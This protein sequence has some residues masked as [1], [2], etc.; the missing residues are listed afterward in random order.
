MFWRGRARLPIENPDLSGSDALIVPRG[1]EEEEEE[2]K[3]SFVPS[4][5]WSDKKSY[6]FLGRSPESVNKK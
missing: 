6:R 3:G 2:E 5:D 1:E 4:L